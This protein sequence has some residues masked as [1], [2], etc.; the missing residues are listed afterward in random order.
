MD[1][2]PATTDLLRRLRRVALERQGLLG[3][4]PFGRGTAA[5]LRAI[6]RLG[7]VQIDSIAVVNRAHDHVL[8]SRVPNYQP[9]H[10][11]ALQDRRRIF[12]YWAHAAAYLPMSDYRYALPKMRAMAR[13][14]D[15]WIRCRDRKLMTRVLDRVRLDGPLQARDFAG[16]DRSGTSGWWN[17]K[18]AKQA[19]EQLFMEGRLMVTARQGFEKVYD[20]TERVLPAE[21]DTR[22]P[23]VEEQAD[24]LIRQ[25]LDAHGVASPGSMLYLRSNSPL[26]QALT[27]RLA[28]RWRR[29]ELERFDSGIS[30]QGQ[31]LYAR[32]GC[33]DRRARPAPPRARI[34]SPF[35][36]VVIQRRRSRDLFG[37]D[38]QL[39][40]YLP[41]SRRRY[42]YFCLPLLYRDGF[43]GRADCKAHRISGVMEIRALFVEDEARLLKEP[44]RCLAALADA[45]AAFSRDNA[46]Q[47]VKLGSV[48]PRR[49]RE[50][51][52]RI[53]TATAHLEVTG[54]TP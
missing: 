35:D 14:E 15:R 43:L 12:E 53:L 33:L 41:A 4:A 23:S 13:G 21:V 52:A 42:G 2:R 5:T 45:L 18:P 24:H 26:R 29:G 51:L 10:L 30:G 32:A 25:T 39:E 8:G 31:P 1:H 7:Y 49:W 28:A 19:L 48:Q 44:E 27:E 16:P 9:G 47:A 6:E 50:P 3:Q 37:F 20:L 36:N 11:E 40:C 34:L 38:Y 46:C 22:M 54:E 17:W